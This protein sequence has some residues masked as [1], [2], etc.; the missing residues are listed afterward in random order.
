MSNNREFGTVDSPANPDEF[1]LLPGVAEAV[2]AFNPLDLPVIVVSNQ[3]GIAKG[4]LSP[5]LL[6]DQRRNARPAC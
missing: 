2:A 1:D 4:K 3:P 5:K 6:D